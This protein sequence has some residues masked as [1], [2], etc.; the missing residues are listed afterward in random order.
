MSERME[1]IYLLLFR[2]QGMEYICMVV[3]M[4]HGDL[5]ARNVLLFS[6]DGQGHGSVTAKI[7]DFGLSHKLSKGLSGDY[8]YNLGSPSALL[9]VF[10]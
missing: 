10:W 4:V 9:P 5:A 2:P 3:K 6:A 8:Y 7:S 1:Y